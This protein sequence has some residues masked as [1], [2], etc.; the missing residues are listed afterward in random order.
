MFLVFEGF[1]RFFL[2]T[3]FE[4]LFWFLEGRKENDDIHSEVPHFDEV[5]HHD[6]FFDRFIVVKNGGT[7]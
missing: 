4:R 3:Y 2:Y 1:S 7:I 6:S 5:Q